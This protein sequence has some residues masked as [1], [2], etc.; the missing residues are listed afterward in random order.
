MPDTPEVHDPVYE[1]LAASEEFSQLRSAYRRF[2]VPATIVFLTWY[3]LYV[4]LSMFASD[5]MNTQ[6]V[7]HI[8]IALVLGLLQFVTTFGIAWLYSRYSNTHLDPLARELT[9]R[10]DAERGTT[11]DSTTEA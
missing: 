8:N 10:F 9:A 3:G 1:R 7:G 11:P 6:V 2:I 4:V 5:F